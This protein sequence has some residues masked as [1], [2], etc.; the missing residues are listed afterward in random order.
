MEIETSSTLKAIATMLVVVALLWGIQTGIPTAMV[1]KLSVYVLV[2]VLIYHLYTQFEDYFNRDVV[3]RLIKQLYSS[4][5]AGSITE[6]KL[7]KENISQESIAALVKSGCL[8]E[9]KSKRTYVIGPAAPGIVNSW[10][11]QHLNG[12][13]FVL[14]IAILVISIIMVMAGSR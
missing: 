7:K 3:K 6:E 1:L 11:T 5:P 12:Q 10:Y 14:T 13:I 4:F 2:G 9:G 8:I